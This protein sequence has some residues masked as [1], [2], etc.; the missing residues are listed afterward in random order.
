MSLNAKVRRETNR[1]RNTDIYIYFFWGEHN[2]G[3]K[4]LVFF[5][6]LAFRERH[7]SSER[8]Q[9]LSL[10]RSVVNHLSIHHEHAALPLVQRFQTES[11]HARRL[12]GGVGGGCPVHH[13]GVQSDEAQP[14]NWG[15]DHEQVDCGVVGAR[16][17]RY[18]HVLC[19]VA[20]V[21]GDHQH[22]VVF[23]CHLRP[24][25]TQGAVQ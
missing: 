5:G 13:G 12:D 10:N 9:H 14:R 24:D 20:D 2:F 6:D 22:K 16:Q 3:G 11:G 4:H 23:H 21:D 25:R 15:A 18:H 8:R 1:R 7:N 17:R 19:N